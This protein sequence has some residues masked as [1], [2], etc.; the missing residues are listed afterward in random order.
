LGL[1]LD[2][3]RWWAGGGYGIVFGATFN[4]LHLRWIE[5]FL[6]QSFGP[7]PWLGLAAVLAVY[8]GVA[9]V[10]MTV[11]NRLPAAP[12][13]LA[14][15]FLLQ[16]FARAWWPAGGFPWGKVA[17]SQPDGPFTSLAALGG[18]P[19]V[20]LL[21]MITGFALAQLLTRGWRRKL[22]PRSGWPG[23]VAGLLVPVTAALAMWPSIGTEPQEGTRTVGVVQG[24]APDI[25]L[26]LLDARHVL[27][28]N[29]IRQSR[30]LL[31]KVQ[32]G[33]VPRPDL[34]VW[35]ETA[36]ALHTPDPAL[37]QLTRGFDAPMLIGARTELASGTPQN[38]VVQSEPDAGIVDQY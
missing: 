19:L 10:L 32:A 6:G 14:T 38:L 8:I 31:H 28:A 34:V 5:D 3:R 4:L 29:H 1:V 30:K 23:P 35:P 11:V 13:W 18:A 37:R 17:F 2:G 22:Q 9:C 26:D 20:G 24:N 12:V 27:R 25:G 15:V 21:V 16:E 36:T 7:S 33:Q